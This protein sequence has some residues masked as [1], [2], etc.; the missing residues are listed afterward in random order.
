MILLD[1]M[2][3]NDKF[4]LSRV[5]PSRVHGLAGRPSGAW[6]PVPRCRRHGTPR[7][8]GR[9][10]TCAPGESAQPQ[11][12][13]FSGFP[14]SATPVPEGERSTDPLAPGVRRL[15]PRGAQR[16]LP[17]KPVGG[18]TPSYTTAARD[19]PGACCTSDKA[20]SVAFQLAWL[21]GVGRV[22]SE[23]CTTLAPGRRCAVFNTVFKDA[24]AGR[25][26]QVVP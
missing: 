14:L 15:L 3:P 11:H 19:A 6:P 7:K 22:G 10:W 4:C 17:G 12:A 24:S 8:E 26:P 1:G 23:D 21:W 2:I 9:R 18:S 25:Q 20:P 16:W 13:L 5:S